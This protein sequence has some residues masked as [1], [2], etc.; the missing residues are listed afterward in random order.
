[1][2]SA[3]NG[4]KNLVKKMVEF[5]KQA[6]PNIEINQENL[7][8]NLNLFTE[9]IND[10]LN[11]PRALAIVWKTIDDKQLTVEEKIALLE[12]FDEV[13]GLDLANAKEEENNTSDIPEEVLSLVQKRQEA[14]Q[15]KQWADADA[16]RKQIH[17]LGYEVLDSKAGAT[18]KKI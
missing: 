11:T 17:D 2:T 5:K 8:E 12:K 1:M 13:L 14:R 6:Q 10:D 15:N 16:L 18:V 3:K 9:A 7:K 4:F